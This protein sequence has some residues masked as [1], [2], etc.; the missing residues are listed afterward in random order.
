MNYIPRSKFSL[1]SDPHTTLILRISKQRLSFREAKEKGSDF[2]KNFY[3]PGL[4]NETLW[5]VA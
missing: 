5:Y 2:L 1:L 4:D 3:I